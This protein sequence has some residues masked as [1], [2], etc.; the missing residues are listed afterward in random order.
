MTH[1]SPAKHDGRATRR[2]VLRAGI[3]SAVAL[4]LAGCAP[5]AGS[6]VA[7]SVA[8]DPNAP[9]VLGVSRR[10]VDGEAN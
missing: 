7:P 1:E 3:F 4:G 2:E 10:L 5:R 8:R 6:D 9:V